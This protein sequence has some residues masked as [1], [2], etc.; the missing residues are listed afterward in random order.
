MRGSV[1]MEMTATTGASPK[2]PV[3]SSRW[4]WLAM[5]SIVLVF[6]L[7]VV[8]S[9]NTAD[10]EHPSNSPDW[11]YLVFVVFVL[12]PFVAGVVL[13]VRSGRTGNPLGA[14]A[15][16]IGSA[17]I[18]FVVTLNIGANFVWTGK[19]GNSGYSEAL[20]AILALIVAG[21]IG[22]AF[23]HHWKTST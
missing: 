18:T 10:F 11:G 15:A 16:A 22:V 17:V 12:L 7:A 3:R 21:A 4:A 19:S 8:V 2:A 14:L 1:K 5:L 6:P 23:R 20:G 9:F 13:G